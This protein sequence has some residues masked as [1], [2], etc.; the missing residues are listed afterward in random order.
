MQP[1]TQFTPSAAP[2]GTQLVND[3]SSHDLSDQMG[4]VAGN[5][6]MS[7]EFFYAH[8]RVE[9]PMNPAENGTYRTALCVKKRPHGDRLTESV[10]MISERMAQ[11]LYPREFA[12]FKQNQDVPTDGTPL[13]EL[14]GI[15]QSQIA[16]LVIHGIRCVEDLVGLHADQV[17]QIGMDARQA[18]SLAKRWTEAKKANGELIRDAAKDAAIEAELQRSREES[19]KA[20]QLI[21]ELT[22]QVAILSRVNGAQGQA[23]AP[24]VTGGV[25][26]ARKAQLVDADDLPDL[27]DSSQLFT[28]PQL[29]TGNDDLEDGMQPVSLPGLDR[30]KKR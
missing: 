22:A 3:Y 15:S 14:P 1:L 11:Q 12:Y 2:R 21:A 24:Q 20:K 30:G 4:Y 18:Y 13:N 25:Q 8:V 5:G 9:D 16:I 10:R 19:D 17:S 29:V 27:S 6:N 23:T 26:E 28:Q 7:I